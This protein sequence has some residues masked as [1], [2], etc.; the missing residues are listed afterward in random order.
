MSLSS[1]LEEEA[2]AFS[3][4]LLPEEEEDLWC[5]PLAGELGEES[6]FLFDVEEEEEEDVFSFD[7][8]DGIFEVEGGDS[9]A[10]F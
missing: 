8:F 2:E 10:G 7:S 4:L 9:L 1:P 6:C 5:F 3:S